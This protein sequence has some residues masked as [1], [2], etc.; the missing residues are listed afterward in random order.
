MNEIFKLSL[1]MSH[2][3]CDLK[4]SAFEPPTPMLQATCGCVPQV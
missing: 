1:R 4:V 3:V 2:V